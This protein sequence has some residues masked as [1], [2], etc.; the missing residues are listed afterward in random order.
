M[1]IK[2]YALPEFRNLIGLNGSNLSADLQ[3]S[4][5]QWK[6]V[7]RRLFGPIPSRDVV[8][9]QFGHYV[10]LASKPGT[11]SL[12]LVVSSSFLTVKMAEKKTIK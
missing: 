1:V 4:F 11:V 9:T 10:K 8:I 3:M 2:Q 12:G 5:S 7:G 6:S